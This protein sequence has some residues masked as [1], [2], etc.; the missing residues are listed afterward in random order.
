MAFYMHMMLSDAPIRLMPC[1]NISIILH[2]CKHGNALPHQKALDVLLC[3]P[4]ENNAASYESKKSLKCTIVYK[5]LSP[6]GGDGVWSLPSRVYFRGVGAGD[7][8]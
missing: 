3:Q 5:N 2:V 7:L 1:I 4:Y 6:L 8:I